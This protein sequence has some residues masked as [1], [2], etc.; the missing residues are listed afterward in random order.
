MKNK[1]VPLSR[2]QV[3]GLFAASFLGVRQSTEPVFMGLDHIEFYVS[4]AEKSRDFFLRVFG[5]GANTLRNRGAKRYLKLGATYLAFEPP[6][7]NASPGQV[8]HFSLAI[9]KLEMPK[10]HAFL[11]QRGVAYQDYPSGRDTGVNDAD[12]IRTQ[13]S[14]ADGWSLL[15]PATF[16]AEEIALPD[17]P[18]FRPL[19]LEHVLLNVSDVE[20]SAA[21][22]QKFLGQPSRSDNA[23]W[24]KTGTS[25]VGLIRGAAGQRPGVS[26]FSVT[27]SPFDNGGVVRRL[28]Q[29]GAQVETSATGVVAFRDL[30]GL[31]IQV[32]G[33]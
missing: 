4:N 26:R 10:L 2:R 11:E 13:L 5:S 9:Q 32:V 24:F 14:P 17:D 19:S 29:L 7:G 21:F 20:Q 8:V 28:Q 18:I 30:D 3:L 33:S 12:G 22:Y 31:L 23:V 27:A 16:P 1:R 15:N 25:R 6:R